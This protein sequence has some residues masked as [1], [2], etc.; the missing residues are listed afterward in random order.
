MSNNLVNININEK[1][2]VIWAEIV[3]LF[4]LPITWFYLELAPRDW[5]LAVFEIFIVLL[6]VLAFGRRIGWRRLGFRWDNFRAAVKQ[7]LPGTAI[8]AAIMSVLYYFKVGTTY[9]FEGWWRNEYFI[10]YI[11]FGVL[12]QEF[13][14]RGFLID[15]LKQAADNKWMIIVV[16]AVLFSLLHSLHHSSMLWLG[17][18]SLGLFWAWAYL[19]QPN[20]YVVSI[21][22]AIIGSVAIILGFV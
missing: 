13:A 3:L 20:I 12:S 2:S 19:K 15:R 21:S 22:H 16:A 17:A 14:F 6:A 1:K 7:F 11:L 18:F 4:I 5:D 9:Y 10:Y 8:I